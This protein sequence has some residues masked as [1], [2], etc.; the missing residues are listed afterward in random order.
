MNPMPKAKTEINPW[1][2]LPASVIFACVGLLLFGL[3][4]IALV[5]DAPVGG[6]LFLA[7]SSVVMGASSIYVLTHLRVGR[8]PEPTEGAPP[9]RK[10]R[11]IWVSLG[12]LA[13]AGS[14]FSAYVLGWVDYFL[15]SV[16]SVS[17][18]VTAQL[19]ASKCEISATASVTEYTG[20]F[21]YTITVSAIV[22]N[23][24][25]GTMKAWVRAEIVSR[26]GKV[27]LTKVQ[28]IIL[29]PNQMSLVRIALPEAEQQY[30][31]HYKQ[32]RVLVDRVE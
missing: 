26:D 4:I 28:G 3:A 25:S 30:A 2:G 15:G 16:R 29:G 20:F 22:R 18:D 14:C 19:L 21:D 10:S 5:S 1:L 11:A 24:T 9:R 31:E 32:Y 12:T 23:R 8:A 27:L 6:T 7:I 13:V 17:Q